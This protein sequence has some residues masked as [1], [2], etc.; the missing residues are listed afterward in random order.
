MAS[1][2]SNVPDLAS[3]LRTLSACTP[4]SQPAP[5]L[6]QN[7][8]SAHHASLPAS[9]SWPALAAEHIAQAPTATPNNAKTDLP[10]PSAIT[11]WPAALKYV[12][13]TVAQNEALQHRIRRLIQTQHDHE[14]KWWETREAL[15]NKQKTRAERKKKL[16]E[17]LRSVG[18]TVTTGPEITVSFLF[19]AFGFLC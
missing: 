16:D 8:S 4:A 7:A 12:M 3:V 6:A 9:P 18:G 11:A 10:D 14:R 1:H 13:R 15:L 17:V 2:D 19:S 5:S